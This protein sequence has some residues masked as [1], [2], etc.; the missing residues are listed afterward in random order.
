MPET[1]SS[2]S[3]KISG[4][5]TLW[6]IHPDGSEKRQ[7]GDP[8]PSGLFAGLMGEIIVCDVITEMDLIIAWSPDG[9]YII[10][11][12]SQIRE[13]MQWSYSYYITELSSDKTR[14]LFTQSR[15][16][17]IYWAQQGNRAFIHSD[18]DRI[19]FLDIQGIDQIIVNS[20][21]LNLPEEVK[22][23]I[24][25]EMIL[26]GSKDFFYGI[27]QYADDNNP[28]NSPNKVMIWSFELSTKQWR[29]IADVSN[30]IRVHTYILPF[31]TLIC[32]EGS[33]KIQYLEK[34]SVHICIKL[35][36]KFSFL[37]VMQPPREI[38]DKARRMAWVIIEA[39]QDETQTGLWAILLRPDDKAVPQ[40]IFDFASIQ[41]NMNELPSYSFRPSR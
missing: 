22:D 31:Q 16:A 20:I 24:S 25:Y 12:Q 39:T 8:V 28:I 10:Y 15:R 36:S 19:T 34:D 26:A 41:G 29:K 13:G 4:S 18:K 11:I 32:N 35:P 37:C 21:A 9:Q 14:K 3:G 5:D 17:D 6:I 30:K 1:G 40:L 38:L 2:G 33:H 27:F 23:T 7:I